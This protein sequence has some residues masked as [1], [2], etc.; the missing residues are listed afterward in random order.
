MSFLHAMKQFQPVHAGQVDVDQ[1]NAG[2]L[3]LG[4]H[5]HRFLGGMDGARD[6]PIGGQEQLERSPRRGIIFNDQNVI[7]APHVILPVARRVPE[8]SLMLGSTPMF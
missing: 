4:E 3:R 6:V 8:A 7:V 2:A 1:D 5:L